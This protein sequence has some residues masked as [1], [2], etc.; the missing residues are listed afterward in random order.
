MRRVSATPTRAIIAIASRACTGDS[1]LI[2]L[3]TSSFHL[4][5]RLAYRNFGGNPVQESLVGNITVNGQQQQSRAW[6]DSMVRIQE[7]GQLHHHSD[8]FSGE[9]V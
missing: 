8:R 1:R 5:Y 2:T 9:H 4:M 6:S 7:R 3:I